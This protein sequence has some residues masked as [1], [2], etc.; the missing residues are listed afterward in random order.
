MKLFEK[1]ILTMDEFQKDLEIIDKKELEAVYAKI[2]FLVW[3]TKQE[4]NKREKAAN[5]KESTKDA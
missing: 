4:L 1:L 5:L 2:V 3:D